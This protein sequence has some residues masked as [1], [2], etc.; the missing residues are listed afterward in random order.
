VVEW[1]ERKGRERE[2]FIERDEFMMKEKNCER[3]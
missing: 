2:E 3:V 1:C